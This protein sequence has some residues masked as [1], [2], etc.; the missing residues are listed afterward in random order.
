MLKED[1]LEKIERYINGLSDDNE[2]VWVESIF[3]R[4]G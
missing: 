1:D 4:R 2:K 3:Q